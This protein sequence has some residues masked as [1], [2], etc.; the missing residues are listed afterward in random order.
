MS[1]LYCRQGRGLDLHART[2]ARCMTLSFR[3]TQRSPGKGLP[4]A[5]P[6]PTDVIT[7]TLAYVVNRSRSCRFAPLR[8]ALWTIKLYIKSGILELD[9]PGSRVDKIRLEFLPS[10]AVRPIG[11][12][13]YS[14]TARDRLR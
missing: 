8:R 11:M 9:R 12:R 3:Q 4:S 5:I 10:E 7:I 13:Q 6:T 2:A 14:T 1:K